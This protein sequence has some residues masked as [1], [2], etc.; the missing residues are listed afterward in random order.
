MGIESIAVASE[1]DGFRSEAQKNPESLEGGSDRHLV[2]DTL[3]LIS[4]PDLFLGEGGVGK[5]FS[6]SMK[7]RRFCQ[8]VMHVRDVSARDEAHVPPQ[9]R[10][11][12]R[13]QAARRAARPWALTAKMEAYITN[14]AAAV[15]DEKVRVPF[16]YRTVRISGA[17]EGE[18]YDVRDSYDVTVMQQ[19]R[20]YDLEQLAQRGVPLPEGFDADRFADDLAAFVRKLNAAGIY[21]RDIA[22]RNVM[23]DLETGNPWLIDFGRGTTNAA[24]PYVEDITKDGHPAKLRFDKTD[25]DCVEGV[26]QHIRGYQEYRRQNP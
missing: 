17:E 18:A 13:E 11:D 22:P 7:E 12:F 3:E 10:Q 2:R 21:H 15:R 16:V 4:R 8:K 24:D 14:R 26:R 1:K 9:Y 20:G 6:F 25:E 5:V 23:L 19:V